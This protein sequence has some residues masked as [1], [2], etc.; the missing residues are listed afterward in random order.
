MVVAPVVGVAG[1]EAS[2]R[3]GFGAP[4]D[5]GAV[6]GTVRDADSSVP[7]M[8]TSVRLLELGREGVTH[9]DGSFHIWNVPAGR[10]TVLAERIGYGSVS[11]A[12]EVSR[13]DTVF[14]E[15][16][17]EP[18]PIELTSVVATGAI[19]ERL[20]EEALRPTEVLSGQR[21]A[22][23]LDVTVA[24]TLEDRPG[25]A[26]ATNGPATARP[27]IRGLGGDRILLL[28]DGQRVGDLS[29]TAPD[30]AVAIEGATARR[31]EV[32][33][34]PATLLYGS[35]AIGG[36]VNVIRDEV[37]VTVPHKV[38]G[39][40]S[41]QGQ[42]VNAGGV[43]GG[44]VLTSLTDRVAARI[45]ASGRLAGDLRTALGDLEN[46]GIETYNA[47]V[48]LSVVDDW[49]HAGA[50]YRI[51]DTYYG[52][53]GG[54]VGA[55]ADGVNVDLRRQSVR[56]SGEVRGDL[57][58]F[59]RIAYDGTVNHYHHLELE[60][61]GIVGTEYGRRMAAGELVGRHEAL[62]PFDQGAAGV[63]FQWS[64]ASAGGTQDMPATTEYTAAGFFFEELELAP[65]RLHLGAR[66]D[67]TTLLPD[68]TGPSSI[69]VIRDRRFGSVSASIGGLVRPVDGVA[70]GVN[71]ARAYRTPGITELYSQGP[72]LA[73]YSF[74]VGTPTLDDEVGLG[75]EA[76]LR[77]GT[78]RAHGE[79]AAFSNRISNYIYPR[80]TGD[81]SP[82]QLPVY[83]FTGADALLQGLEGGGEVEVADGV[84][85]DGTFSY[86]RGTLTDTDEPLPFIPP[87]KGSLSAR[88][89]RRAFFLSGGV[90]AA[91]AQNRTG[92]FETATDG[93]VIAEAGAG[94]RF[95][96]FGNVSLLTLSAENLLDDVYY[97]HL[98]RTKVIMPEPGRNVSLLYRLYF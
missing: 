10:Y 72:H 76:F 45:E 83:Q 35:N 48:G 96:T 55:H 53:P 56:G 36:V 64:R 39:S 54:F 95:D 11:R 14:V 74:E 9:A 85:L 58:P 98:S 80:D 82:T 32:V 87:L 86:V 37:P 60:S 40:L 24:E 77:I 2:V 20:R 62:G 52:I 26:S 65:F 92:A 30:H 31:I 33:R 84:V 29:A 69:G 91:A 59:E 42:S 27:V 89:D 47:S 6:V 7:L 41:V 17:M 15:L 5:S 73:A 63:R 44:S 23:N 66:Y 4:A 43:A 61:G 8:G 25:L 90:T 75:A 70:M 3:G 81:V 46:T 68:E 22:R 71:L 97:D 1:T 57:G 78:E 49:G 88:Y 67:W 16:V 50:A 18:T 13:S 38:I 34:G 21:L 93:Y 51:Y 19:G 94:L 28:E 79:L 12:V